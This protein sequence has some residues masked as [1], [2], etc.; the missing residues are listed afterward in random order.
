LRA[1]PRS[2]PSVRDY[3]TGLLPRVRASKRTLGQ[4]CVMRTGGSHRL[5]RRFIRSQVRRERWLRRRSRGNEGANNMTM[6]ANEPVFSGR[7]YTVTEVDGRPPTGPA[8]LRRGTGADP[9]HER[10][11][12]SGARHRD[13]TLRDHPV[14]QEDLTV[15]GGTA[16]SW[17]EL[18]D[19][20]QRVAAHA[21]TPTTG[22]PG[23]TEMGTPRVVFD[24][25]PRG[26][27]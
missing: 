20:R 19:V 21:A 3:R 27:P 5:A 6:A 2:D 25:R 7:G 1:A 14:H 4:G 18:A 26:N 10:L 12:P 22:K 23:L 24:G 9:G 17:P 13:G 8:R 16:A 11:D 15:R